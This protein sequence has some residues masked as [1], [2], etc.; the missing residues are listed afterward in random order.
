MNNLHP[1]PLPKPIKVRPPK[2]AQVNIHPIGG[3][4][5]VSHEMTHG[6]KVQPWVFQDP[7]KM[8]QH[9]SKI[10]NSAWREPDRNEG[11][12]VTHDLNLGP[13]S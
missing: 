2:I 8:G 7:K 4:F 9:L 6:P 12:A 5:K 11:P 13:P 10:E 1:I 3:G